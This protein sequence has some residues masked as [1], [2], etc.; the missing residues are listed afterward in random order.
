M[1]NQ[2]GEL[3]R[4]AATRRLQ[5][6]CGR[7]KECVDKLNEDQVWARG[8]E[9]E[10]A[11][12]N[13]MLHLAGNVRQWILSGVAGQPDHRKRDIE[14]ATRG[15]IRKDEMVTRLTDTVNEASA[16]IESLTPAQLLELRT[17]QK[18]DVSV[19]EAVFHVVEH[20]AQHTAQ[21]VFATKMLT[22]EDMG[23]YKHLGKGAPAAHAEKTP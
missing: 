15:D 3:F 12:G 8:S 17:I 9:N 10:N 21:I 4:T 2:L 16:V 11:I 1:E 6:F 7:I 5:Q 20:F 19:L 23:F 13:L 18:Y 22:H 14:F